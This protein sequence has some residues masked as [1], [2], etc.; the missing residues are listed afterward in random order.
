M[1]QVLE[2]LNHHKLYA[3]LKK[4]EFRKNQVAYL[5]HVISALGVAVD[6]NKVKAMIEW[7][8]PRN[9]REL[10]GFLGLTGYYRKFTANDANIAIPPTEQLKKDNFGWSG[11]ATE[12]F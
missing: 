2:V 5:G 12:V 8:Q 10:R 6:M 9:L 11:E 7:E 4:C 3:N 1:R